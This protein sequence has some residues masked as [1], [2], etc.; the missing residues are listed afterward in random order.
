MTLPPITTN[1]APVPI[2]VFLDTDSSI[3]N[4]I[5]SYLTRKDIKSA[6]LVSK[7]M[8]AEVHPPLY[9]KNLIERRFLLYSIPTEPTDWK[10]LYRQ[11]RIE[12]TRSRSERAERGLTSRPPMRYYRGFMDDSFDYW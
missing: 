8:N 9:W 11:L 5:L 7:K 1:S 10:E 4:H 12:E 2:E 6:S 3:F